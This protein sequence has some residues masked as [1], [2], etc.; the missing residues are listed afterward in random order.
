MEQQVIALLASHLLEDGFAAC[1]MSRSGNLIYANKAFQRIKRALAAV[2]ALPGDTRGGPG[3][4]ASQ[5]RAKF[6]LLRD[7]RREHYQ[8]ERRDLDCGSDTAEAFIYQPMTS[9]E[10]ASAALAQATTRLEDITRLVSD[11]IWETD[12]NLAFTYISSTLR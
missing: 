6:T 11:W 9:Q 7:G 12:R 3:G 5:E 2:G 10:A 1:L 8:L 4:E